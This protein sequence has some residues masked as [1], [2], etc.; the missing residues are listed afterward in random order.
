MSLWKKSNGEDTAARSNQKGSVLQSVA[1]SRKPDRAPPPLS[2][3][4]V[5]TSSSMA[6]QK[7]GTVVELSSEQ[8]TKMA[9]TSKAMMAALGEVVALLMRLPQYKH[10]TLAELEWLV[11]PALVT[12]QF[13]L[14]TAQ[15][16]AN[17]LTSPVGLVM[18]ATVSDAVD[19]RLNAATA[20]P[21]R[22]KPHEWKSGDNI[23]LVIAAGDGRVVQGLLQ[24]LQEKEWAKKPAKYFARTPENK[25]TVATLENKAA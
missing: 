16:K 7:N 9:A 17:G 21:I 23:W 8:L 15:S 20:E 24:R 19:K 14:A 22:L 18:W 2:A 1:T 10:Y 4:T 25:S 13:S 6:P 3:S 12:G 5:E 11:M